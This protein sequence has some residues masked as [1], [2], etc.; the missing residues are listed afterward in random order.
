MKRRGFT[1]IEILTVMFIFGILVSITGYVYSSSLSRSRDTQRLS[2][3]NNIKTTLEQYYLENRVY[4]YNSSYIS[5]NSNYARVAKYELEKYKLSNNECSNTEDP[6]YDSN[7]NFLAPNY[8]LT[9]PEDPQYK[10]LLD[11][12]CKL[13]SAVS[14]PIAG[15][16]QYIYESLVVEPDDI[17][18]PRSY[19]LVA[20]LE[21]ETHVSENVRIIDPR[22][23]HTIGQ[24]Y[25]W[26][27]TYC[28]KSGPEE[29]TDLICTH[30]YYLKNSNN[31]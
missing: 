29:P 12:D 9:V 3:L 14:P 28:S 30:N 27:Y 26:E 7:K 22:Y 31:D 10:M 1:L 15:Y 13:N 20:R 11:S 25:S 4:P 24:V 2:D 18:T 19:Y 17:I 5:G 8:M 16:G 6:P 23:D 21:R